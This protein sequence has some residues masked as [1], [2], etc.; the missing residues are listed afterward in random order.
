[1]RTWSTA[2]A[3]SNVEGL[4]LLDLEETWSTAGDRR[5]AGAAR[6]GGHRRRPGHVGDDLEEGHREGTAGDLVRTW[7]TAGDLVDV[8][9]LELLGDMADLAFH[10]RYTPILR[11]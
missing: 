6:P 3:W 4:G 5:G 1:V 2:D 11:P 10:P 9:D 8:E 7:S